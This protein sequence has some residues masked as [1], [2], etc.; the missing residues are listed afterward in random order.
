ML[1]KLLQYPQLDGK[2]A[3]EVA[4]RAVSTSND[5]TL[6]NDQAD[7]LSAKKGKLVEWLFSTATWRKYSFSINKLAAQ[8][9]IET[10]K[11]NRSFSISPATNL[12][13]ARTPTQP[14]TQ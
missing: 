8:F 14:S 6:P 3:I 10:Q 12:N 13:P 9:T 2:E 4:R 5:A 1:N 7:W 11:I